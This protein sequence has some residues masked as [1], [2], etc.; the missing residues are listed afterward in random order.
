MASVIPMDLADLV[1]RA[2]SV[3]EVRVSSAEA[4]RGRGSK[5]AERAG[6]VTDNRL[7]VTRVLKGARSADITI[8]QPGGTVGSVRLEVTELPEF[9][10]G[11]RCILFL[12]AQGGVVGGYQ[13]KLL[14]ENGQ[15]PGLGLSLSDA[16]KRIQDLAGGASSAQRRLRE[17]A[18]TTEQPERLSMDVS[19]SVADAGTVTAATVSAQ[20]AAVL[21]ESTF[22]GGSTAGWTIVE[23][24][25]WGTTTYKANT[26]SYSLYGG[27]SGSLGVNPPGPIPQLM[28]PMMTRTVNLSG[29]NSATLEFDVYNDMTLSGYN[30]LAV[31][32]K[33]PSMTEHSYDY[34]SFAMGTSL[35]WRHISL[36]L[37]AVQDDI[38]YQYSDFT[39]Q[40]SV[41]ILFD[42]YHAE[43]TADEGVYV[44]NIK[45]TAEN[46]ALPT[47]S[48]ISPQGR[49]AGTHETV[50]ITGTGFGSSRGAGKVRFLH[51]ASM[52][53][54]T[55]DATV[56]TSWTDTEVVCEVPRYAQGGPVVVVNGSG[57]TSTGIAYTTGFSTGGMKFSDSY[58]RYKI[59]ENTS[60]LIGEGAAIQAAFPAWSAAG[61]MFR[62]AYL[63]TTT[64]TDN[65]TTAE[66]NK[67]NEIFFASSGFTDSGILAWNRYWYEG[68]VIVESDIVFNDFH[69]WANGA[70]VGKF[71]IQSVALHE[72]GHTVGLDDQYLD[73]SEVMGAGKYNSTRRALTQAEIN[74]AIYVH[75]ADEVVPPTAPVVYSTT[76]GSQTAWYANS[77]PAFTFSATDSSGIGGYSYVM[78]KLVGTVPDTNAEPGGTSKAYSGLATGQWYFHVRAL[79]ARGNWGPTT[80]RGVRIDTVAPTVSADVVSSYVGT[81]TIGFSAADAHSQVAAIEYRLDSGDWT[82]GSAVTVAYRGTHSL[83]VRARDRAG[84]TS[85]ARSYSFVVSSAISRVDQADP[86]IVYR[87]SW[88]RSFSTAF[89]QGSI[90]TAS[91]AS[92]SVNLSFKGSSVVLLGTKGPS[93]GKV[94]MTLDNGSPTIVDL[95]AASTSYRTA[96]LS[97][98]GL[99]SAASHTVKL[100][101][102]GTKNAAS[103]GTAV[104]LD[105]VDIEG[106]VTQA[107]SDGVLSHRASRRHAARR[108]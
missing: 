48:S 12:N 86:R 27:K 76:H 30:W 104:T 78:D 82:T 69:P 57:A 61:S 50:T 44:D 13:G 38:T 47:V 56:Y 8:T 98:S 65:S 62:V 18:V 36:D 66:R 32:F 89:W 99:D 41:E 51:G 92:A 74:G 35:G 95:Y 43:G 15:V 101:W 3:V 68:S 33:T 20:A 1:I 93:A 29:Y 73:Y 87:G 77:S 54:T 24:P 90:F 72:L 106:T 14:V 103:S 25:T 71:D 17:K 107:V 84:N 79:D 45:L 70:V 100:E 2:D 10:P 80:T 5:S 91:T 96:L 22:E 6:I 75:G 81:A 39:G 55:V 21:F 46:L 26:G 23:N 58:A 16:R 67:L 34:S 105:A 4:R 52:N 9:S 63:G 42:F 59:N 102:T 94:R 97:V 49:N 53:G 28:N 85:S 31:G 40:S 108:W 37:R 88:R 19:A 60:D 64:T 83:D 7:R 11:E